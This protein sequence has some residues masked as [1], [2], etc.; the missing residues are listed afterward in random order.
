MLKSLAL[1]FLVGL[2]MGDIFRKLKLPEIL[3]MLITGIILGPYVLDLFHEKILLVSE[4]LRLIALIIILLKA[5]LS[6]NISELKKVGLPAIKLSFLPATFEIIGYTIFAPIFFNISRL[7]GAL[8]GTVLA[9]VSPA[10]VVPRMVKLIEEKYGTEKSIPQMIMAAGSLDDIYVIILFSSFLTL[11]LS[12]KF[13]AIRLLNIPISIIS[14]VVIG[15]IFGL[16]IYKFFEY[17]YKKG[18]YIRNSTKVVIILGIAFL[19]NYFEKS[20]DG[21]F[22][23]SSLLSIITMGMILKLKSED[24]VSSRLSEKFGKLWIAAEVILFVLVGGEVDI[25]YT[26]EAGFSAIILIF[27]T[28]FIRS[29]GVYIALLKENF[30][31]QEKIFIIISYLPKATVQAAIGSVPMTLGIN[32]GSLILSVAVLGI[33]ITAPLGAIGIDKTYKK[34]L[35]KN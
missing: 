4:D 33:L 8:M 16:F 12:G 7:D 35:E 17:R 34:F 28:L 21:V 5:G 1:I 2:L 27:L 30:E 32:S 23:F 11:A 13:E 26:M 19:L 3:G 31:K 10:V 18:D 29:I 6:L 22:Q 15:G 24:F 20:L 14:G 25:R 9:A